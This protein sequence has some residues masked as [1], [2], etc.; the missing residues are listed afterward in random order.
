MSQSN[1]PEKNKIIILPDEVCTQIVGFYI[2]CANQWAT[3]NA[4]GVPLRWL[5]F[6]ITFK[7]L[8]TRRKEG[9]TLYTFCIYFKGNTLSAWLVGLIFVVFF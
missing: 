3:P 9:G 4:L 2:G 1:W 7:G 6:K 8:E 5:L